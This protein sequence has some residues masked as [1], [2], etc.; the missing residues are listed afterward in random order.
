MTG[1]K[2]NPLLVCTVAMLIANVSTPSS[3]N[4]LMAWVPK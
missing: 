2:Y 1:S 3:F 4:A